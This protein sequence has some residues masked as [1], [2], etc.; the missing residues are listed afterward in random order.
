MPVRLPA[1]LIRGLS[2]RAKFL[3]AVWDAFLLLVVF[4]I[5]GS[6]TAVT[7]GWWSPE[8]TYSGSLP[9]PP[10]TPTL[11]EPQFPDP[12][13]GQPRWIRWDELTITTPL[14]LAQLSHKPPF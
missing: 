11:Y 4:G 3:L 9:A 6:S 12:Q 1:D 5:H 13:M 8:R 7:A 2:G 14:A 10:H